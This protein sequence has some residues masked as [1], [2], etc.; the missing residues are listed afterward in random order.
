MIS[1]ITL[2]PNM[3]EN[4]STLDGRGSLPLDSGTTFVSSSAPDQAWNAVGMI[5]L[6]T[7]RER[8]LAAV[9]ATTGLKCC[10]RR[11]RPPKKKHMPMTKRRLDSILP[12][13]DVCT[14]STSSSNKAMMATIN[15]TAFL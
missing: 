5:R 14:M 11:L 2:V 15:S 8:R 13:R 9:C 1:R 6:P 10:S 7:A 3:G 4:S 12:I